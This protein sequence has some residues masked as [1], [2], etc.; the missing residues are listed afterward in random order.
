MSDIKVDL[1]P[2]PTRILT[3]K[4]DI[5]EKQHQE[6]HHFSDLCTVCYSNHISYSKYLYK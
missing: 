1:I 2:I 5:I 6:R 4:D 3:E